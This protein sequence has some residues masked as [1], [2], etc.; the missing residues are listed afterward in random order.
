MAIDR[1]TTIRRAEKLVRDGR[2]EAAIAEYQALVDDQPSDWNSANVLGD[3]L[4]RAGQVDKAIVQFARVAD[5][6]AREGFL[7][8]AAALYKKILKIRP[9]EDEAALRIAEVSQRQ[10]LVAAAKAH[11]SA[12]IERRHARGDRRGAAELMVRLSALDPVDIPARVVAARALAQT[13]DGRGAATEL[14]AIA[15]EVAAA[16]R[17][18]EGQGLLRE[19]AGYDPQNDEIRSQLVQAALRQQDLPAVFAYART[20][21][22]LKEAAGTLHRSGDFRASLAVIERAAELD[23]GDGEATLLLARACARLGDVTRAR[24]IVARAPRTGHDVQAQLTRAEVELA[25][26]RFEEGRVLLEALLARVPDARPHVVDLALELGSELPQASFCCV[27]AVVSSDTR[28]QEWRRAAETLDA[29]IEVNPGNLL[30]LVRLVEVA[31]DGNLGAQVVQRAR[32]RLTD[33]YLAAG[34]GLEARLIAEDLVGGAPWEEAQVARLRRAL[35]LLGEREPDRVIVDKLA[36]SPR[37][38]ARPAG[39]NAARPAEDGGAEDVFQLDVG[40]VDVGE[41]LR[42]VGDGLETEVELVEVDLSR[43]IDEI[44]AVVRASKGAAMSTDSPR[45]LEGV[46]EDFREEVSRENAMEE[47]EQQYTLALTYRDMGLIDEA[48]ASLERAARSPRRRFAA[49]AL[50]GRLHLG[51]NKLAHAIEWFERAA[52]A[53]ASTPEESRALL[54]ELART[55]EQSGEGARALAVYMELRSDADDYRDVVQRIDR[56]TDLQT[57]G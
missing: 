27:D 13:G 45:D 38:R 9:D 51:R 50:L 22:H 34:R 47:A 7:P 14:R 32:E 31:V 46:F 16:G 2:L 30:P 17:E 29:V 53:P 36:D 19:A 18:S 40:T 48:M 44:D 43:A 56:L 6:L 28:Q 23:P 3:L 8:K 26:G 12:V 20:T 25:I 24:A 54:Y 55:L 35:S 52:E 5:H 41:I 49:A 37:V 57:K 33:A 1:D 15:G 4:V 42:E 11:L 39:R 21:A 10:G